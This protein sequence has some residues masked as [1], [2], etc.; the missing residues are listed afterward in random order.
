VIDRKRVDELVRQGKELDSTEGY[1]ARV[2]P[3]IDA[4]MGAIDVRASL[5]VPRGP[6]ELIAL[7]KVGVWALLPK[8]DLDLLRA[9]ADEILRLAE[10]HRA[11]AARRIIS[12]RNRKASAR[13]DAL[14]DRLEMIRETLDDV[15]EIY[16]E[17]MAG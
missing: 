13:H 4:A 3:A 15:V 16:W 11:I 10:H 1:L 14:L 2:G 6:K 17:V 5:R 9:L 7:W 12:R 8:N